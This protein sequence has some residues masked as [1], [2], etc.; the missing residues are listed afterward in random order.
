VFL[1]V[2]WFWSAEGLQTGMV[3]RKKALKGPFS[4]GGMPIIGALIHDFD[5]QSVTWLAAIQQAGHFSLSPDQPGDKRDDI[6]V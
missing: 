2:F 5:R 4:S 6:F 3:C 1:S